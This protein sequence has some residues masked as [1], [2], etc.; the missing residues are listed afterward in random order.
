MQAQFPTATAL[1][2]VW[3]LMILLPGGTEA[4]KFV[5]PRS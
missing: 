2:S 5:H 1:G 3:L 4:G